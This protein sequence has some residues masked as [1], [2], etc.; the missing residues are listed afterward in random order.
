MNAKG[1]EMDTAV[2][3][4][5]SADFTLLVKFVDMCLAELGTSG[6]VDGEKA[7]DQLLDLRSII[8]SFSA[9]ATGS[10]EEEGDIG[11]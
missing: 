7:R 2:A 5:D 4:E 10:K 3:T 9:G 6:M 11:S 8:L 1:I